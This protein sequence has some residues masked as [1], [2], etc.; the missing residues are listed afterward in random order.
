[1]HRDY[2]V[3]FIN[4]VVVVLFVLFC[5][6]ICLICDHFCQTFI[7]NLQHIK[8]IVNVFSSSMLTWSD[9]FNTSVHKVVF[10]PYV[11]IFFLCSQVDVPSICVYFFLCSQSDVPSLCVYFLMSKVMSLPCVCIFLCLGSDV[12]SLCVYF[13]MFTK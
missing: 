7:I 1:M 3:P 10:L 2:S 8:K 4:F 9:N 12:P 13:Y 11:C 5:G 6:H